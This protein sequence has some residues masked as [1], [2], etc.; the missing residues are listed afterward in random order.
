LFRRGV[1]TSDAR[2]C[3]GGCGSLESSPH[4]FL[5]CRIFWEVWHLIHR[6]LG[7]YLVLPSVPADYLNQF[8]FVGGN[9]SMVRQSI[10]HVI[11]YATMWEI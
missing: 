11:W 1:I 2:F 4:L 6:W 9:C 10:M 3:V 5:H 7:V 8:G